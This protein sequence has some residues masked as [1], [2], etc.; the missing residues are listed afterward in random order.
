VRTGAQSGDLAGVDVKTATKDG[1]I[2]VY[3]T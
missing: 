2:P 1:K 3:A